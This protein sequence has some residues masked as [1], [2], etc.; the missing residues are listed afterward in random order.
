[1]TVFH[2][3]SPRRKKQRK[4]TKQE[5]QD[6]ESFKLKEKLYNIPTFLSRMGTP[7]K[8]NTKNT[9][10]IPN[11]A[12]LIPQDRNHR[13]LPSII[14]PT[15]PPSTSSKANMQYTGCNM[16]GV[17]TLHKSNAIPVF[18]KEAVI[19]VARMRR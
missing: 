14:D 18:S 2:V 8:I 7:L 13:A 1:M 10:A 5:M 16:L 15:A 9:S 6:E 4:R 12:A 17:S 19:D 3:Q 11:Y